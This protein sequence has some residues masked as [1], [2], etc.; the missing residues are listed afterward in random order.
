MRKDEETYLGDG[1]YA[2]FDGHR[3]E[4]YASDGS[5]TNRVFLEPDVLS[6]FIRYIHRVET[7]E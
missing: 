5:K 2:K 7:S 4:L 1:L 6:A 3:F